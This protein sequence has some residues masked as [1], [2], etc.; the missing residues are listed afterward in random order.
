MGGRTASVLTYGSNA[1]STPTVASEAVKGE[2]EEGKSVCCKKRGAVA[3]PPLDLSRMRSADL[4][5][6]ACQS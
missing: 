4:P 6:D 2:V 1:S 5:A 3:G